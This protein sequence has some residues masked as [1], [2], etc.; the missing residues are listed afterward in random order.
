MNEK[1]SFT[2]RLSDAVTAYMG[3]WRYIVFCLCIIIGWVLLNQKVSWDPYP[4]QFLNL[5]LGILSILA[6]PFIMMSQNR[7]EARDEANEEKD[8]ATDLANAERLKTLDE[9]IDA[10]TAILL[11]MHGMMSE[12][13]SAALFPRRKRSKAIIEQGITINGKES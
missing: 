9:K 4:H 13:L 12:Q 8:L 6:A 11:E 5:I 10:H 1:E 3:S 7:Q 2:D